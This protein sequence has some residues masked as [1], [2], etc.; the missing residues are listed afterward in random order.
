MIKA[1]K[2]RVMLW[3]VSAAATLTAAQIVAP[4]FMDWILDGLVV[5][6]VWLAASIGRS[7]KE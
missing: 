4:S 7:G 1:L 6:L 2:E 3:S 5:C